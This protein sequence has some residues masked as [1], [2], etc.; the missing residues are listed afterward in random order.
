MVAARHK[1][2]R[3]VLVALALEVITARL[4]GL[5]LLVKAHQA[6]V[7]QGPPQITAAELAA[8]QLLLG[9]A[10]QQLLAAL[11]ALALHRQ[12]LVHP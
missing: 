3:A 10:E 2:E 7:V 12:L 5:E 4:A 8:A 11:A 6:A 1:T 9:L